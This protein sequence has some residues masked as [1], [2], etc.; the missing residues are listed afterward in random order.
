MKKQCLIKFL[1]LM[2]ILACSTAQAIEPA[3][4]DIWDITKGTVVDDSSPI[5]YVSDARNMFG[6]NYYLSEPGN[7]LFADLLPDGYTHYIEWHT[8]G[9]INLTGF[10]LFAVHDGGSDAR[11]FQE[12]RIYYYNG[13]S[14]IKFYT[15]DSTHPYGDGY[16]N[17]ELALAVGANS[18]LSPSITAEYFRA[19]F[20]QYGSVFW[21]SGPRI[22]ELDGFG[23]YLHPIPEPGTLM[24]LVMGLLGLWGLRR[25]RS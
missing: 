15:F 2:F 7:T 5:L 3:Y 18:F 16:Q 14:W 22:I 10:N 11:S 17:N 21:A 19:E 1:V 4:D 8:P 6:G 25:K 20:D 9:I 12:F 23:S 13:W 24:M